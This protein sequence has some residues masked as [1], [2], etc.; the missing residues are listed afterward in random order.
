MTLAA[1]VTTGID[2]FLKNRKGLVP[3]ND[4]FTLQPTIRRD[5]VLV[6]RVLTKI[7]VLMTGY[8]GIL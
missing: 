1:A 3:R 8:E 5:R 4:C 2:A 7:E 6:S